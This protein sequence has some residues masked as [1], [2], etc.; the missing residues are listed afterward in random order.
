MHLWLGLALAATLCA[1]TPQFDKHLLRLA[2]EAEVFGYVAPKVIGQEKLEQVAMEPLPRFRRRAERVEIPYKRRE[3]V[4]EYG[5]TNFK[6]DPENLHEIRQVVSVDGKQVKSRAEARQTLTMGMRGTND[7][8]KKKMLQEFQSHGLR[9]AATEFGQLIL[10]FKKRNQETLD[11]QYLRNDY[12]GAERAIVLSYAQKETAQG[13][14]VFEGRRAVQHRL[15]GELWL[16]EQ[17]GV[18]LRITIGAERQPEKSGDKQLV[19]KY[20]AAVDY[21]S[22]A[23][24]TL[25]PASVK[26]N[27]TVDG[28]LV[29][30]N[31]FQY[32]DF[33]MFGASSEIKFTV[34]ESQPEPK[35]P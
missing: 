25:L 10:L 12:V 26:Y 17:D 7:K 35:K 19:L 1:K 30:E 31:R 20:A 4:S 29:V 8:L 13:L 28:V 14:T 21:Q 27:E 34:E 5:Y 23:H 33:R 9:D 2:E 3:I 15:K 16:R 18:P 11:F 22:S 24:G 6:D 32:S